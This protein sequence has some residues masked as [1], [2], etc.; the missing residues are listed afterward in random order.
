M[1]VNSLANNSII[2]LRDQASLDYMQAGQDADPTHAFARLTEGN[3]TSLQPSLYFQAKSTGVN[4]YWA[5]KT[6][7]GKFLK[8]NI[9]PGL[10]QDQLQWVSTDPS[11][12][13][14]VDKS[15][16]YFTFV[17]VPLSD[18]PSLYVLGTYYNGGMTLQQPGGPGADIL[19][20]AAQMTPGTAPELS[21]EVGVTSGIPMGLGSLDP[22]LNMLSNIGDTD[23][24][25]SA[26]S[27]DSDITPTTTSTPVDAWA[28]ALLVVLGLIAALLLGYLMYMAFTRP[29]GR[30]GG[31]SS[32]SS[33]S[34]SSSP[35]AK[36]A[37][38]AETTTSA[39]G[40][41]G[42]AVGAVGSAVGAVGS[43]MMGAF[44]VPSSTLL[45]KMAGTQHSPV[46][47]LARLNATQ[48][49]LCHSGQGSFGLP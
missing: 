38:A 31:G 3:L 27:I 26:S 18:S 48:A 14:V 1:S 24:G 16:F 8:V 10:K 40:A 35:A 6:A 17:P 12:E 29:T 30:A 9:E 49:P 22:R 5:L 20:A 7:S 19:M 21:F 36:V 44:R 41:V 2:L 25:D 28:V 34:S 45:H 43:A 23:T 39:V 15:P 37:G 11:S 42:S 47:R 33:S 32:P 46:K 4:G 13:T